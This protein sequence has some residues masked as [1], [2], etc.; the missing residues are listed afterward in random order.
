MPQKRWCSSSYINNYCPHLLYLKWSMVIKECSHCRFSGIIHHLFHSLSRFSPRHVFEHSQHFCLC[1]HGPEYVPVLQL[2]VPKWEQRLADVCLTCLFDWLWS[3]LSPWNHIYKINHLGFPVDAQCLHPPFSQDWAKDLEQSPSARILF[4]KPNIFHKALLYVMGFLPY[5]ITPSV[6]VLQYAFLLFCIVVL[7][8]HKCI[9][10]CHTHDGTM[11]PSIV[12]NGHNSAWKIS[13]SG[14]QLAYAQKKLISVVS[15]TDRVGSKECCDQFYVCMCL[16]V[17]IKDRTSFC[18]MSVSACA[19]VHFCCV[20]AFM[21]E[22]VHTCFTLTVKV[23]VSSGL[24]PSNM[25][26]FSEMSEPD[27]ISTP[28]TQTF[29]LY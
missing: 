6:T 12:I 21:H 17:W 1:L 7:M 28:H 18:C 29:Q 22:C 11:L 15:W 4:T 25:D 5:Q 19:S 20:R 13:S 23:T 16:C 27:S 3:F 26:N 10:V 24:Y 9:N 14:A 2:Q 8:T